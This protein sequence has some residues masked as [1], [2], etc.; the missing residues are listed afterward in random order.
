M[1]P[2]LLVTQRQSTYLLE[3]V[4]IAS[5][6]S[7]KIKDECGYASFVAGAKLLAVVTYFDEIRLVVVM[8]WGC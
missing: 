2:L 8:F 4:I 6:L 3:K 7:F 1:P 5:C